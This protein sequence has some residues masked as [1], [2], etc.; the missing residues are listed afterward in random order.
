MV[1]GI[2]FLYPGGPTPGQIQ[3]AV[4]TEISLRLIHFCR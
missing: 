2:L 4:L 3:V 1:S